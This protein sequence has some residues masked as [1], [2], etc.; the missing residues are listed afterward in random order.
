MYMCWK[1][2]TSATG[3]QSWNRVLKRWVLNPRKYYTCICLWPL[4][5]RTLRPRNTNGSIVLLC[6]LSGGQVYRLPARLCGTWRWGTADQEATEM[7]QCRGSV[8]RSG[9]SPPWCSDHYVTVVWWGM[10]IDS[11]VCLASWLQEIPWIR[12]VVVSNSI[13]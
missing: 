7:S 6:M 12:H 10:G 2:K 9:Q 8:W 4:F 1:Y 13:V 3:G 11:A 5:R